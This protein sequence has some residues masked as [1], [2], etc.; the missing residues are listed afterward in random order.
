M[1]VIVVLEYRHTVVLVAEVERSK[2][3]IVT[4]IV[5]LHPGDVVHTKL[6]GPPAVNPVIVVAALAGTAIFVADG[7]VGK[8]DQVPVPKALVVTVS[9]LHLF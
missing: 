1:T 7:L 8:A 5:S 3:G 4:T 2:G 6:Y 9:C